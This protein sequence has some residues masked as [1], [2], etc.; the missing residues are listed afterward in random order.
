MNRF[1]KHI[2]KKLA[3]YEPGVNDVFL[4]E[5]WE[6][7]KQRLE[8]K[9]EGLDQLKRYLP[10][11]D[12]NRVNQKWEDIVPYL[13][14]EKK[15]RIVIYLP[16]GCSLP[17]I[18]LLL[19][20]IG[21]VF[22]LQYWLNQSSDEI[23]VIKNKSQHSIE[24]QMAT[25]QKA[26]PSKKKSGIVPSSVIK[27][28][29]GFNPDVIKPVANHQVFA[30]NTVDLLNDENEL[31]SQNL[32]NGKPSNE[33]YFINPLLCMPERVVSDSV[34]KAAIAKDSL[35][36]KT[37]SR[38]SM[39]ITL[40]IA[41]IRNSL[42]IDNMKKEERTNTS[43]CFSGAL[44]Y[45]LT[46]RFS[47]FVYGSVMKN[48]VNV[49]NEHVYNYIISKSPSSTSSSVGSIDSVITYLP[50]KQIQKVRSEVTWQ[51]G[52]GAEVVFLEKQRF[53]IGS[54]IA[55]HVNATKLTYNY[56]YQAQDTVTYTK[57]SSSTPLQNITN[58]SQSES[59]EKLI[60]RTN[61]GM[62]SGFSLVYKNQSSFASYYQTWN[63]L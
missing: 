62:Y 7:T 45:R 13:P 6:K 56:T 15:K 3:G 9:E 41:H 55:F 61:Y 18:M 21:L 52:A 8:K 36:R 34:L 1:R 20:V 43:V 42:S 59:D 51:A 47:L 11:V 17:A 23:A 57:S 46:N 30:N 25:T 44:N 2:R 53:A 60:L 12:G 40:G 5:R 24:K 37:V 35:C 63:K 38:F 50:F 58:K 48:P 39:D 14:K 19:F 29:N 31:P 26:D 27:K 49:R 33:Q 28:N 4:N 22:G 32:L 16:N 10:A 54:F